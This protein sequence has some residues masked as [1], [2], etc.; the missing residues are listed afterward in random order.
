MSELLDYPHREVAGLVPFLVSAASIGSDNPLPYYMVTGY[1]LNN[2][3]A[4]PVITQPVVDVSD[5]FV[6]WELCDKMYV[7]G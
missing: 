6:M 4:W 7:E 5:D 1:S 2:T 3:A